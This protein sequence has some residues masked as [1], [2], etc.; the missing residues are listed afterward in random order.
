MYEYRA[1][2]LKVVDGDTVELQVKMVSL[3]MMEK[4]HI[5]DWGELKVLVE[6][7]LVQMLIILIFQQL[8]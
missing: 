2:V 4:H 5:E 7:K 8:L 3:H 1:K 6:H